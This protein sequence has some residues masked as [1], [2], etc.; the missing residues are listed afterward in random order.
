VAI[1][2]VVGLAAAA[3]GGSLPGSLPGPLPDVKVP[4]PP[5]AA[6]LPDGTP[7]DQATALAEL[8]DA[9]K[10]D[11]LPGWLTVYDA[12]GVP[13]I[14]Q[15]GRPIGVD[16]GVPIGPDWWSVW[17]AV[18]MANPKL[19][20]GMV[21]LG[22]L[23]VDIDA[24]DRPDGAVLGA[25]LLDDL[26]ADIASGDPARELFGAFIREK[27]RRGPAGVDLADPAVTAEQVSL[28]GPTVQLIGWMALRAVLVAAAVPAGGAHSQRAPALAPTQ[29]STP[30]TGLCSPDD[31][32]HAQDIIAT[33][34]KQILGGVTIP[35]VGNLPGFISSVVGEEQ[36]ADAAK[37]A[38]DAYRKVR[39]FT[40][41][42]SLLLL[43]LSI[44][45]D[46]VIDGKLERTHGTSD[47]KQK[48]TDF[49]LYMDPSDTLD[50]DKPLGCV[51][52]Y[53]AASFGLKLKLPGKGPVVGAEVV[54]TGA[55]GFDGHGNR[56]LFE[57]YKQLKQD[58]NS[59]GEVK[60][61]VLGRRQ[62]TEIP[63]DAAPIDEEFSM[64][65]AAQ[66]QAETA[67]SLLSLF[68]DSFNF[69]LKPLAGSLVKPIIDLAK[70]IHWDF[71]EYVFPMTDWES[72]EGKA[73]GS[74]AQGV[75]KAN[76]TITYHWT[77][78]TQSSGG[79]SME[80]YTV[81]IDAKLQVDNGYATDAGSSTFEVT[82]KWTATKF[83]ATPCQGEVLNETFKGAGKFSDYDQS[84]GGNPL[85][86][87]F[88]QPGSAN[89]DGTVFATLSGTFVDS[90]GD[91]CTTQSDNQPDLPI[92]LNCPFHDN[93][94]S[95]H[96]DG[97]YDEKSKVAN[98]A[99]SDSTTQD[100]GDGTVTD[101]VEVTGALN[102]P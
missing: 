95:P 72:C 79:T 9:A 18:R 2:V 6:A 60:I 84:V 45:L 19:G 96:V 12:V 101:T 71:G 66:P 56:V 69:G 68:I 36:G 46:G 39:Q 55:D 87:L 58:T 16:G 14:G 63:K 29:T 5:T 40:D 97:T 86:T 82:G 83:Y 89:L 52:G 67:E 48:D 78:A 94:T 44:R 22:V 21:D 4:T 28:D 24:T 74:F 80:D 50:G 41:I 30:A 42:L 47:G 13:V 64:D 49:R 98:L 54:V 17:S 1:L 77:R 3:C 100:S 35:G 75:C 102:L 10:G 27:V 59:H 38:N 8:T 70:A 73:S 32:K 25:A 93:A 85:V 90:N 57:D 61:G 34:M 91:G 81:T 65:L 99:C 92:F 51:L 76:T 23:L 26:R 7:E 43:L 11:P 20:I 62:K 37:A 31:R 33:A 88:V 15:D 53:L